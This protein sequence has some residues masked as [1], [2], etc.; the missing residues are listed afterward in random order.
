M[1][2]VL[3][4]EIVDYQSYEEMREDLRHIVFGVKERRRIHVGD[5][6]T[7]LFEN[8]LTVRYQIQ[9]MMRAEKIVREKDIIHE[10]QTYNSLIGDDGEL[11][12][13]L[14]IEIDDPKIRNTRLREWL[15]LPENIYAI[16]PDGSRA[17]PTFDEMQRGADRLSSVQYLKFAVGGSVPVSVGVDLSGIEVET[18]LTEDQRA[19]LQEDL[20]S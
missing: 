18:K 5:C 6:F 20:A 10:L 19:A 12:C 1:K 14:L 9:E 11:G 16:M 8:A 2:H 13:T 17:R 7:F 4:N 3:R 15:K